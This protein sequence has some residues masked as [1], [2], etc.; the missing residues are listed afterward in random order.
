MGKVAQ[1]ASLC[2]PLAAEKSLTLSV[3]AGEEPLLTL[4][5][6]RRLKQI[7]SRRLQSR[8]RSCFVLGDVAAI[9]DDVSGHDGCESTQTVPPAVRPRL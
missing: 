6:R 2:G 9:A 1:A 8:Q 4:A 7:L 5:D 3:E